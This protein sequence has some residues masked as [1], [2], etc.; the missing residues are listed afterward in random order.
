MIRLASVGLLIALTIYS[1]SGQ[2]VP[3]DLNPEHAKH[4]LAW[5]VDDE[6]TETYRLPGD[7]LPTRYDLDLTTNIHLENEQP[8]EGEVIAQKFRFDGRVR[9]HLRV[10]KSTK[11]ITIHSK[12]L[13]IKDATLRDADA[14]EGADPIKTWKAGQVEKN[15][16]LE[17]LIFTLENE[18]EEGTNCTLEISYFGELG[19]LLGFYKS[20]YV[21][22]EGK[23]HWLATTQFQ[24]TSARNAY[25]CFDEPGIRAPIGLTLRH[26]SWYFAV[27]NMPILDQQTTGDW[28]TTIFK[29]TPPMQT[30]L[31]AFVV[32]DF[33]Y[34]AIHGSTPQRVFGRKEFIEK[35]DADFAVRA[36]VN[37]LTWLE[38]YLNFSYA[39]NN[40]KMDQI[41]I[42]DFAAGAMENWGLVTYQQPLLFFD[43]KR[44]LSVRQTQVGS[45][46][47]HE[48]AH[49][50]FGNLVSPEW[51][52]YLWLNEGFATLYGAWAFA[53]PYPELSAADIYLISDFGFALLIDGLG[54]SRP[55]TLYQETPFGIYSLFDTVAYSK[56]KFQNF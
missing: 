17:F 42:P 5:P 39:K 25:P 10:V 47:A 12:G 3:K 34:V 8:E 36:G 30:Y 4:S 56:C 48:Y 18:L 31:L 41:G 44:D 49:Q 46:I 15:E 6:E 45:T 21:D 53:G 29:D 40:P 13:T 16:K 50:F 23:K 14:T 27:S 26:A 54:Q 1:V 20:S 28:T 22:E 32:H 24:P 51:W 7:T 55:M 37:I 19:N 38:N 33:P 52:S 43:Q 35:G 2:I 11:N 9:I